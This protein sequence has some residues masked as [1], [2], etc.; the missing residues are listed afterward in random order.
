MGQPAF[1]QGLE[2]GPAVM[3]PQ[4]DAKQLPQFA[5][6]IRQARGRM[7]EHAD[8]KTV[9]LRQAP[10]QEPQDHALAAARLAA[11]AHEAA[12]AKQGILQTQ[13]EAVNF[14]NDKQ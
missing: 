7:T 8:D 6:D 4:F 12:L 13:A 5:V 14:L 9:Q 1:A 10:S 11:D 3:R 2:G